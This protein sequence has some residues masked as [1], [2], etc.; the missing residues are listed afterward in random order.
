MKI[1]G[2]KSTLSCILKNVR[3]SIIMFNKK[4]IL[5]IAFMI[6]LNG[7]AQSTAILGPAYTL[8]TT[9]NAFQAGLSYGSNKAITELKRN[10]VKK[11][12]KISLNEKRD[13]ELR[14]L[15]KAKIEETRKKIN[16]IK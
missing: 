2:L 12:H 14:K 15:L 11:N 3:I 5:A 1:K 10:S 9:G 7:C 13:F 4:I 16:F 6:F 8:G